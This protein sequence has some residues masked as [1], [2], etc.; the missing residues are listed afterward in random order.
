MNPIIT[1]YH[2][3]QDLPHESW[4]RMARHISSPFLETAHL[5][6]VEASKINQLD[7]F[8]LTGKVNGSIDIISYFFIMNFDVSSL[9]S[10]IDEKTKKILRTWFPRFMKT[11]ML[12]CGLISGIGQTIFGYQLDDSLYIPP[13]LDQIDTIARE[14]NV[15]FILIRDIEL[16]TYQKAQSCFSAFNY[17]PMVGYPIAWM[18]LPW[19]SFDDYLGSLKSQTF[20]KTKTRL[21]KLNQPGIR[22]EIIEDFGDHAETLFALW[23]QVNAR[24]SYEHE[25]LSVRYFQ[26]IN[27]NMPK[28]SY[29]HAIKKDGQIIAFAL[30][31]T[32]K[33]ELILLYGGIDYQWNEKYHLYFNLHFLAIEEA[34]RLK[35]SRINLGITSY[36]FKMH[37]GCELKSVIYLLKHIRQPEATGT[38]VSMLEDSIHYPENL[39]RPFRNQDISHRIQPASIRS[40]L[41]IPRKDIFQ[42]ALNYKRGHELRLIDFHTFFEPFESA[43]SPEIEFNGS[44]VIMIGSN[45]YLGLSTHPDLKNASKAAIDQYGTGCSGSP[46]LNGTLDIHEELRKALAAF[47]KKEEAI[48]FSTG[49]Q[50][51]LGIISA[52]CGRHDILILDTSDHASIYDGARYASGK[53]ERYKHNDMNSLESILKSYIDKPKLIIADS[54]FSMEGTI[55]NLPD[56]VFLK[57]KYH[58]RL[59]LDEAHGIG[60]L[61][62]GGRG[63]AEH[64]DLLDEVDIIMGTF[65][66]SF[67]AVGGFVAG[68]SYVIDYLRHASRAYM[69]SASLPPSVVM[70]VRKALDIIIKEPERRKNLIDNARFMAEGLI[71][72]G[73]GARFLGTPIVPV[74]CGNELLTLGLY[75]KLF[76]EGVY[77]N[78][79]LSPAVPKNQEML[80]TSYMATHT[81]VIL[82]KALDAFERVKTPDFP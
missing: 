5:Q 20:R 44:P 40:R 54:V 82:Q 35:K 26:E 34:I 29:I 75:K 79:V 53:I 50:T 31:M 32:S 76:E 41:N 72:L 67:A 69:F 60:V 61:G 12:E 68:N 16:D 51:N 6:A 33:D 4:N 49:Y 37:I 48:I 17:K 63:V 56:M 10:D 28:N 1:T 30:C 46:F 11:K 71:R 59:M 66:K 13:A 38:L 77:V 27:R 52:L 78:P 7:H 47:M 19:N 25:M 62:A 81:R 21:N 73:Y 3:I 55:C 70:T 8:Y 45:S 64:F 42:K 9:K 39:H 2:S 80:R 74:H 18:A 22:I 43:Q 24:G 65:S 57:N 36:D 15:D 14:H 58:A 23:Q